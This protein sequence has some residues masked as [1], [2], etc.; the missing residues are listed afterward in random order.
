M[1]QSGILEGAIIMTAVGYL[2]TAAML[3]LID[4][5]YAILAS[6]GR[7]GGKAIVMEKKASVM[8]HILYCCSLKLK[9]EK[10]SLKKWNIL[11]YCF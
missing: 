11:N 7:S 4:C 1:F 8:K 5:K 2:S 10:I 9:L 3:M 6:G